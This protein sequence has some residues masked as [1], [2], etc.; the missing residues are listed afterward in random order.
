MIGINLTDIMH[1][2]RALLPHLPSPSGVIVNVSSTPGLRGLPHNAAYAC[3]KFGVIG[4]TESI[5]GEIGSKG[6]RINALLP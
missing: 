1:C 2:M 3:S 5:T 6:I 4:W